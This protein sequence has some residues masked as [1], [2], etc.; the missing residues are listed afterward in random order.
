MKFLKNLLG[1]SYVAAS[2]ERRKASEI[3]TE[4]RKRI[5]FIL[6]KNLIDR[7]YSKIIFKVDEEDIS[8]YFK[9]I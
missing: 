5:I 6:E 8:L 3:T 2:I 9:E 1:K 4:D 7:E